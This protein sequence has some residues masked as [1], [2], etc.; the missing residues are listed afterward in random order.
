MLQTPEPQLTL[1]SPIADKITCHTA[2][3]ANLN[4]YAVDTTLPACMC[5]SLNTRTKKPP[6]WLAR[7]IPRTWTCLAGLEALYALSENA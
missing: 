1:G 3:I 5:A 7:A 6:Q 2:V 4:Q